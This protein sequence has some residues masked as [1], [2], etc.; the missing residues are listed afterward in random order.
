MSFGEKPASGIA[1][2]C[3]EAIFSLLRNLRTDFRDKAHFGHS[4]RLWILSH[5]LS[6]RSFRWFMVHVLL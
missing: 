4:T 6:S 1:G 2:L 5:M 3:G